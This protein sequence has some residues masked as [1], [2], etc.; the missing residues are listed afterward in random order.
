MKI[1]RPKT[2]LKAVGKQS[3]QC[4]E[5]AYIHRVYLRISNRKCH[6]RTYSSAQVKCLK[7]EKECEKQNQKKKKTK[8]YNRSRKGF[9]LLPHFFQQRKTSITFPLDGRWD[10][11]YEYEWKK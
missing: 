1:K 10:N 7:V 3:L 6:H 9:F 4:N 5:N 2:T 11:E 8:K